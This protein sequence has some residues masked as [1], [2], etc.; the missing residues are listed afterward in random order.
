[1]VFKVVR[2]MGDTRIIEEVRVL[3]KFAVFLK[4]QTFGTKGGLKGLFDNGKVV[5]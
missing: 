1:V 3:I 2:E 4:S 5:R